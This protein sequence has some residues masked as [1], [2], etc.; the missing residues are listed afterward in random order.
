MKAR[1]TKGGGLRRGTTYT[2]VNTKK[3]DVDG[4]YCA[5]TTSPDGLTR[6]WTDSGGRGEV[7]LEA[8]RKRGKQPPNT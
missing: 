1:G 4:I 3:Q 2:Q 7:R 8:R 5:S 6:M